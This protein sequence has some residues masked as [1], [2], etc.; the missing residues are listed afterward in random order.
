MTPINSLLTDD[1]EQLAAARPWRQ[2]AW[3]RMP[4]WAK[5]GLLAFGAL[6]VIHIAL[7][8]RIWYGL[9]DPPE[10]AA[11]QRDPR[12]MI[13][14]RVEPISASSDLFNWLENLAVGLR[15][16][17]V[18]DVQTISMGFGLEGYP[19]VEAGPTDKDVEYIARH[20]QKIE[21]LD[22]SDGTCSTRALMELKACRQLNQLILYNMDIDDGVAELLPHL[23]QL[24]DLSVTYTNTSDGLV[25]AAIRHEKLM[26]LDVQGT[27]VTQPAI[28][29]WVAAKPGGLIQPGAAHEG[30][31]S[32]IRW[33]D[34][35]A[36]WFFMY[37]TIVEIQGPHDAHAT[38]PW[39]RQSL[40]SFAYFAGSLSSDQLEEFRDGK[41][42][43][44]ISLVL[45]KTKPTE[46]EPWELLASNPV[47]FEVMNGVTRSRLE[48][49]LPMTRA[50][51]I[52]RIPRDGD[53]SVDRW[54]DMVLTREGVLLARD[55]L[56]WKKVGR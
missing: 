49:R 41:Y 7:G 56:H 27:N 38:I 20:F 45:N 2:R 34:G 19:P 42:R 10:V 15:G 54:I 17:S 16:R 31:D 9:Q 47:E 5:I 8:I 51:A 40:K 46:N 13:T 28:D 6:V 12:T 52:R 26:S 35:S 22:L 14:Y 21:I 44:V 30:T 29:A 50:E 3:E 24:Y 18:D 55:R 39:P 33:S 4:G 32:F 23:P 11:M 43:L 25:E 48:I 37:P 1:P 36:T 53:S